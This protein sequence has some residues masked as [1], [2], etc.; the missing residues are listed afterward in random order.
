[1][2]TLAYD[3]R[4]LAAD[5]CVGI[6]ISRNRGDAKIRKIV[7]PGHGRTPYGVGVCGDGF[8]AI[9]VLN[10]IETGTEFPDPTKYGIEDPS[11]ACA[12]ACRKGK[13][14]L[15]NSNGEWMPIKE[16][17]MALGGGFEFAIG[18]LEAGSGAIGAVRIAAK[19]SNASSHGIDSFW[20]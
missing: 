7:V 6:G 11:A 12:I 4:V 13:V 3:G 20:V 10:A 19:R 9:A 15:I 14:W 17:V 5:R 1:M 18:A 16:R 2:T 8:H